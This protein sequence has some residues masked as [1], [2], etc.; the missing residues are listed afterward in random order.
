MQLKC[1]GS[2]NGTSV[3]WVAWGDDSECFC[4]G[5]EFAV[6]SIVF[7]PLYKKDKIM[8]ENNEVLNEMSKPFKIIR[9]EAFVWH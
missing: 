8:A 7:K 2:F 4:A 1:C 9:F 6:R 3:Q 5:R